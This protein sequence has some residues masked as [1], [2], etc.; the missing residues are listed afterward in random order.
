MMKKQFITIS[1]AL[2][3]SLAFASRV[4]SQGITSPDYE[5]AKKAI[6]Q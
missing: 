3:F 4:A 5:A 2:L 1:V 6:E